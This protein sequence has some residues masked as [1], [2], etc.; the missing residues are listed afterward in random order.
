MTRN[1]LKTCLKTKVWHYFTFNIHLFLR[2]IHFACLT[3]SQWSAGL[4]KGQ[5]KTGEQLQHVIQGCLASLDTR[6]EVW[7]QEKTACARERERKP[8]H[9]KC[10]ESPQSSNPVQFLLKSLDDIDAGKADFRLVLL[11][12]QTD[13]LSVGLFSALTSGDA[14]GSLKKAEEVLR[15]VQEWSEREMPD[16][17]EVLGSLHNCIGNA[18]IELGDM[19]KALEHH[20]K[21]LELAEQWLE[22]LLLLVCF[23]IKTRERSNILSSFISTA[24]S[25]MQCPELW[26]TS[27][28]FM[29]KLDSSHRPLSCK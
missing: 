2:I 9:K 19:D 17:K 4:V 5:T 10:S 21:D 25:Q 23:T 29:P 22:L 28:W 8:K 14:E 18:L 13:A 7:I 6:S 26:V 20:Q 15:I 12:S 27:D 3:R 11:F 24:T 16:K 1:F